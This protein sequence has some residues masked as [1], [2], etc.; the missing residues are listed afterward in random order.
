MAKVRGKDTGPEMTVRRLAHRLG[1]RFRLHRR[2]LPARPDLVF[3]KHRLA[4]LVH[5]CFWH[6]HEGCSRATTP[7]SRVE[8]WQAKFDANV[9]RDARQ[10]Q[11]LAALGWRTLVVWECDLKEQEVLAERLLEAVRLGPGP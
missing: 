7:S 11:E 10:L 1:L 2:D 8:F 9:A 4:V 6:R 5:G 3:P